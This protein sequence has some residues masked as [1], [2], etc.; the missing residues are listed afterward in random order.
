MLHRL[1][2]TCMALDEDDKSVIFTDCPTLITED[3]KFGIN[4]KT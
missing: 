4:E 2:P 1:T 3:E